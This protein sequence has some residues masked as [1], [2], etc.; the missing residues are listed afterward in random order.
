MILEAI[1]SSA[2]V[3]GRVSSAQVVADRLM[4]EL[5]D[6]AKTG[7]ASPSARRGSCLAVVVPAGGHPGD[8]LRKTVLW[9]SAG[10]DTDCFWPASGMAI[11]LPDQAVDVG[12]FLVQVQV[13]MDLKTALG[14]GAVSKGSV[15]GN[16]IVSGR[17]SK[18]PGRGDP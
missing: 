8:H 17:R 3:C 6:A 12:V 15:G 14:C 16:G 10:H 11:T 2:W 13:K 4:D 7:A 9:H 18:H 5:L 1:N